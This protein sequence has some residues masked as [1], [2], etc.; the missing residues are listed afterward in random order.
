MFTSTYISPK[1]PTMTKPITVKLDSGASKHYFYLC[2]SAA[3]RDIQSI[4]NGPPITLPDRSKLTV[5]HKATLPLP[6][7]VNPLA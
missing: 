4:I 5:N 6:P 2:E 3:L 7:V 1:I